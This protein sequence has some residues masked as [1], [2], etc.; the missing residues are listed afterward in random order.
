MIESVSIII[1]Q[2]ALLNYAIHWFIPPVCPFCL[3]P[4]SVILPFYLLCLSHFSFVLSTVTSYFL[5]LFSPSVFRY[6]F[7]CVIITYPW[8]FAPW[9]I[10][11]V[12]Y[13]S[14]K[15]LYLSFWRSVPHFLLYLN[16]ASVQVI[17]TVIS[18][19]MSLLYTSIRHL[20]THF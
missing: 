12:C 20:S 14:S 18:L 10:M 1:H 16:G 19:F 2:Y 8:C 6:F 17:Y 13:D 4:Y 7:F 5:I 9:Y 11:E 3:A 15:N